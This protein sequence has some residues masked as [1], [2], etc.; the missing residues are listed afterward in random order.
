MSICSI[1]TDFIFSLFLAV[2]TSKSE[3]LARQI[4]VALH[5]VPPSLDLIIVCI[6]FNYSNET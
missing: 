4:E 5:K 2:H 1:Y 6:N 3:F